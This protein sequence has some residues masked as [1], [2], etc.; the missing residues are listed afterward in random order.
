MHSHPHAPVLLQS[1]AKF[2]VAN[3]AIVPELERLDAD[4]AGMLSA[5][6][7]NFVDASARLHETAAGIMRAALAVGSGGEAPAAAT[8]PAAEGAPAKAP[9]A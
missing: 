7:V 8:E 1:K 3:A 5:S 6:F 4:M 9:S 2:E